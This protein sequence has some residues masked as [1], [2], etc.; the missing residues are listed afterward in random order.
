MSEKNIFQKMAD[1][2]EEIATVAK[3]LDVGVGRSSYK[4][5]GEADI[6][7]AVKPIEKKHGVYSYPFKREIINENVVVSELTNGNT[8]DVSRTESQFLRMHT[9]YRFTNVDNPSEFI[10]IDSYGDG[11]DRADKAPGKAMTYSDKY[12][13]MKAYKIITGEDPDQTASDEYNIKEQ[14]KTPKATAK[15]KELVKNLYSEE[16]LSGM[17]SRLGKAFDELSIQE[18]SAMISAR[19]K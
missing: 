7:K 16:E 14:K 13:L 15:Q 10:D 1:I 12:A 9:V 18:A 3:N 6:L 4:A 19:K 2:T 5:A 17:L 8:G 11:L